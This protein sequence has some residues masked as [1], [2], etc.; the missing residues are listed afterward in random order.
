M[1][2]TILEGV[3]E[4]QE[5]F[6]LEQAYQEGSQHHEPGLVQSLPHTQYEGNRPVA[7]RDPVEQPGSTGCN[8]SVERNSRVGC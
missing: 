8:A 5:W 2:M 3:V 6:G 4:K 1:V 7:Y